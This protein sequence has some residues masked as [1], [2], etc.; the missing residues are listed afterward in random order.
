MI[1][2][3]R[4]VDF[5]FNAIKNKEKT[6]EIR[7]NDEK[8]RQIKVGDSID[9]QHIDTGDILKVQVIN[10]YKFDTFE[11]LFNKFDYKKLGLKETDDYTIMDNFYTKEEQSKYGALAIEIKLI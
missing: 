6:I 10:L 4:L 11:E 8:R 7:L 2:R 5:A 1:H 9:F 3:M